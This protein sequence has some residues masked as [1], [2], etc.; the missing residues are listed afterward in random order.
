MK[1]NNPHRFWTGVSI[2]SIQIFG[3]GIW[4]LTKLNWNWATAEL[5]KIS[6]GVLLLFLV[7]IFASFL[8]M[9]G[10]EINSKKKK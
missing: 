5:L 10:S 3:I 9:D 4:G 6:S 2:I 8:I 7:N 1:I